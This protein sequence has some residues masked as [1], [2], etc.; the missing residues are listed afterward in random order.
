MNSGRPIN[1]KRQ[2]KMPLP[3]FCCANLNLTAQNGFDFSITWENV[4]Y[5]TSHNQQSC[6]LGTYAR[7]SLDRSSQGLHTNSCCSLRLHNRCKCSKYSVIW[8][9]KHDVC[10]KLLNTDRKSLHWPARIGQQGC[11]A[12]R[13]I[14]LMLFVI[15][16]FKERI[17]ILPDCCSL[18]FLFFPLVLCPDV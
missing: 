4:L 16:E 9:V 13:C 7:M 6:H 12:C 11:L 5:F 2:A 18:S 17:S 14:T 15:F 3:H 8:L 1:H 10:Q